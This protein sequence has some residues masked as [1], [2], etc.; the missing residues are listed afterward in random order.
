LGQVESLV[1]LE[2]GVEIALNELEIDQCY[3]NQDNQ[4]HPI[5]PIALLKLRKWQFS[6]DQ[7]H[8]KLKDEE[9]PHTKE[10][11]LQMNRF[12]VFQNIFS[13]FLGI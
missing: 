3:P 1:G 9:N 2:F 6:L 11:I 10:H 13:L 8:N 7:K 4:P 5:L 12:L